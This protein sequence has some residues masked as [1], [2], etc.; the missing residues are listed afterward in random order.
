MGAIMNVLFKAVA[1]KFDIPIGAVLVIFLT[2][3]VLISL[4]DIA[5]ASER[6]LWIGAVLWLGVFFFV[7]FSYGRAFWARPSSKDEHDD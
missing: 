5:A 3:A 1:R 6:D 4:G 2:V 7:W